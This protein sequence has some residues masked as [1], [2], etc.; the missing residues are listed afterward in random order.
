PDPDDGGE[1]DHDAEGGRRLE[2]AGVIP[3][4]LVRD[5]LGDVGDGTAVL[6]AE[7]EPLDQP[8]AEEDD[9]R[10]E[11]DAG[12][13]GNESNEGGRNP[14]AAQRDEEC[15]LSTNP[16]TEPAEHKR[17]QGPDQKTD[18][19]ERHG[20]EEGRDRVA[21]FEEL[22]RE[23]RGQASE[24]VEVVPLN[25]VPNCRGDHDTAK[26][27]EREM[28][29]RH[30]SLQSVVV[31]DS[32]GE[33][34]LMAPSRA[35]TAPSPEVSA[36]GKGRS[37][38]P[39]R[40]ATVPQTGH[41]ARSGAQ[42]RSSSLVACRHT[43]V[44]PAPAGLSPGRSR[45]WAGLR[46][47]CSRSP[48][49]GCYP[50]PHP[51]GPE[52]SLS[53]KLSDYAPAYSAVKGKCGS[54]ATGGRPPVA[55]PSVSRGR[56]CPRSGRREQGQGVPRRGTARDRRGG[57]GFV[58]GS[59]ALAG[60]FADG[61]L[62]PPLLFLPVLGL[63]PSNHGRIGEGRGVAEGAPLGDV[64]EEPAHDLAAPRL[65]KVGRE[66]N[67]VGAGEGADLLRHVR[68]QLVAQLDARGDPLL[69]RHEGGEGLALDLVTPADD[70]RFRDELV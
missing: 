14:H 46:R 10:R 21:L 45:T 3:P 5:V 7:A 47:T 23:D 35:A 16:V 59:R 56:T 38:R 15:V 2:P 4:L 66:D 67:V 6:A 40:P 42:R 31:Y 68:L 55:C 37:P 61:L 63:E 8:E 27:L 39:R 9:R 64:A 11:A 29:R 48:S 26:C 19:E 34:A 69:D 24:D 13:G 1:R 60:A 43:T 54:G 20:A 50:P 12:V 41:R 30:S 57:A 36:L 58:R 51:G 33:G 32:V 44:R 52:T 25:H 62:A 22:D 28:G 53:A 17:P 49:I 18:R 70:G 65:G